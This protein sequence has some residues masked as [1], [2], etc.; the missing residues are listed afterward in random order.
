MKPFNLEEALA[1]KLCVTRNGRKVQL[2]FDRRKFKHPKEENKK[3]P[4]IG[5]LQNSDG[6]WP[7][8]ISVWLETGEHMAY[9]R[10]S[11]LDLVGMWEEP[12]PEV[13]VT[14]KA[15]LKDVEENQEVW[16]YGY[17]VAEYL[18]NPKCNHIYSM[19]YQSKLYFHKYLLETGQ[20]FATK[21]DAEAFL[22]AMKGARR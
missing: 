16:Y 19:K 5:Y 15:P 3:Y 9:G 4:L 7:I 21:E 17:N 10:E 8:A 14:V 13:T 2:I 22:E 6:S 12:Q 11:K 18:L 20:L 1:G